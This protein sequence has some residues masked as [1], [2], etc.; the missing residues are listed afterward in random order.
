MFNVNTPI[1]QLWDIIRKFTRKERYVRPLPVLKVNDT[2]IDD[3][4]EVANIF[5][6]IYSEISSSRNYRA[7]FREREWALV[8]QLP[9]FRSNNREIYNDFF[10]MNELT[11]SISKCGST[12][13]G[14]DNLHYAFFNHLHDEHLQAILSMIN[15][16]WREG[17]IPGEWKHSI[18]VPILKPGKLKECP[19]SYRPIQLTSCFSKIMERMVA[20]RLSWFLEKNNMLSKYQCAFRA[21]R[22]TADHLVRFD[23]EVRQGFFYNKYTLG[24]FLDLKNAYTLTSKAALLTKMCDMGF[25][26]RLM[27]FIQ[28]YLDDRTFQ[29][30]NGVLS[31]I[32]EQEN[33]LVQG[34]VISPILFNI[35]INDIF[36]DVPNDVS[37]A[38]YAD[39][40]ALWIQG[41]HIT[42]LINKMQDALN[43]VSAWTD[44][45]GLLFS[46]HKC[47]AVIFR[48]YMK[49]REIANIPNLY[50]YGQPMPYTDT[51][52]YL[53]IIFDSRLNLNTMMK[54]VKAKAVKRISILKCLAGKGCGADRSVLLRIYKSMIRPILEYGCQIFDGPGNKAVESIETVQND[55]IR[56]ATGAYRTSPVLPLLVEAD[57]PPLRVRRYDL[58][59]RYSLKVKS[60]ENHPCGKLL[61][62]D[63]ALHTVDA[64]Y[65]KRISGFP[66]YERLHY[67]CQRTGFDL[68]VQV[69]TKKSA[70]P[71]WV[72]HRCP[73]LQLTGGRKGTYNTTQ[74]LCEFND[75]RNNFP[76]HELIYTDG[77]KNPNGVGCAFIHGTIH[78]KFKLTDICSV[79]TAEAYAVFQA[80][81]YIE[82]QGIL[83]CLICTDSLSVVRGLA[84]SVSE[85]P[86]MTELYDYIHRLCAMGKMITIVWIPGHCNIRGNEAA[87]VQAKLAIE[88]GDIHDVQLGP[89][90]FYPEI[91]RRVRDYFNQLWIN[92]NPHTALKIIKE[93]TE[94]W[95][96][97]RRAIR[98]EEI[99]LCRLRLGHTR[100]THS[101]L[102]DKTPEPE[103]DRCRCL[104]TVQHILIDCP[105][106]QN[107][108]RSMMTLCR[109]IGAQFCLKS[110]IGNDLPR[111]QDE[112]F[113]FLRRCELLKRL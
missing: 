30:R 88:L 19:E 23:S 20:H 87:D 10:T 109:S 107:K 41:R 47:N 78:R 91:R 24:V 31:D 33:G 106:Y 42:P 26:G 5:G 3:P 82:V 101:Y 72:M 55:C 105:I 99:V 46:P 43:T 25:R 8:D 68:S 4:T 95:S 100:Y 104:I 64:D 49:A 65:M 9:S 11:L 94:G 113:T 70:S 22:N 75:L 59:L 12:S 7:T 16:I 93:S 63:N 44:R 51:V 96:S 103:C 92:Y 74:I 110:L 98:R 77:A 32:F 2:M 48:R 81:R 29:V 40:C 1:Q 108:R 83:R 85:D 97:C 28:S 90:A 37:R 15:F 52:K 102:I 36:Q 71:P 45:W 58:S 17:I 111:L 60:V 89:R 39:D 35:M 67:I 79:F 61:N 69:F 66:L 18:V 84:N 53:G 76:E 14:P 34:G 50:I 80:L 27:Y 54:Y 62:N 86:I 57:V 6:N 112:V 21:G 56:I 38:I 13:M 73:L